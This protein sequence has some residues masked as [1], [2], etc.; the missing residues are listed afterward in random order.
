[1]KNSPL[2]Q[3]RYI[4]EPKKS[5]ETAAD[6]EERCWRHRLHSNSDGNVIMPPMAFKNCL[7]EAARFLSIKIPGKGQKTYTK[8]F[9]AGVLVTEPLVIDVKAADVVGE[10][11]FVPSDGV[12]GGGKRVEKIFPVIP[13]WE[14]RV[15]FLIY[16]SAITEEVFT[17]V[18]TE[19]GRF[20]GLGRF[21]PFNGGYYGRFDV[22]S[23]E[24]VE[25]EAEALAAA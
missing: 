9:E 16:D 7:T 12:K 4:T 14:G 15:D 2:S 20:V 8:S 5:K 6:H 25:E 17:R 11:M 1:M 18:L 23:I 22:V 19:A 24:W 10:R 3:S 13:E 21:R